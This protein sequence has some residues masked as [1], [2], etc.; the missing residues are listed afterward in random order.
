MEKKLG[1]HIIGT[2]KKKPVQY[3]NWTKVKA[4]FDGRCTLCHV[5]FSQGLDVMYNK[6]RMPGCKMAHVSC[7]LQA[8][9]SGVLIKEGNQ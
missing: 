8:L 3:G 1:R 5:E 2:F 4:K 9:E 6:N 7:L